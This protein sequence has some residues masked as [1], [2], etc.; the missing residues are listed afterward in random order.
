MGVEDCD[1]AAFNRPESNRSMCERLWTR[2]RS[3]ALRRGPAC[4]ELVGGGYGEQAH[5]AMV[6][7]AGLAGD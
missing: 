5:I 1:D 2:P 3:R 4:I 6:L 7:R